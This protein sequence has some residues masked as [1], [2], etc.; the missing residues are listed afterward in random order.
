MV[1]PDQTAPELRLYEADHVARRLAG[2]S[3][4]AEAM[5]IDPWSLEVKAIARAVDPGRQRPA[6][7]AAGLKPA[8]RHRYSDSLSPKR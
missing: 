2:Q 8:I 6:I 5:A 7:G 4:V 1:R 3:L